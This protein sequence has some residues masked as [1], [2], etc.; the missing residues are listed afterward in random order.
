MGRIE[1]IVLLATEQINN[2][3]TLEELNNLKAQYLSK[4]SEIAG[5]MANFRNMTP[6][7]RTEVGKKVNDAKTAILDAYVVK[8]ASIEA[9]IINEKLKNESIDISLPS[10]GPRIGA[11]NQVFHFIELINS[12]LI[13]RF[14]F[15]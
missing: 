13:H 10:S 7:E 5:M 6:E 12:H 4:K 15:G 9:R 8:Q 11:K 3:T 1:E 2:A 14:F